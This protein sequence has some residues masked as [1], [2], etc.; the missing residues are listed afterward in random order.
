MPDHAD[1][2]LRSS[3]EAVESV[4]V[5]PP[6]RPTRGVMAIGLFVV[7][8]GFA[9]YL[10]F[11]RDG[12]APVTD[13]PAAPAAAPAA[14]PS[15][16]LGGT[17]EAIAV[18]PLDQSDPLVRDLVGRLS[19]NPRVAAWLTTDGLIRNFTVVVANIA[20]GRTPASHLRTVAPTGP[21]RIVERGGD[22]FIDPRSYERYDRLADA[23]ASVDAPGSARLYAT[24]KP[25]I[26]EASQELGQSGASFDRMMERAIVSL[27]AVPVVEGSVEVGPRGIVYG[28]ADPALESM[29][30]AQK[31]LLRMGPRNVR[32]IQD[33][34]RE[35][36]QALGI[37]SDRLRP[38]R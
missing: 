33:K 31:H 17:P 26:E 30:P 28:Y 20:E 34:L 25:R 35:I 9:I 32:I 6:N 19:S 36:A 23:V 13:Q 3:P 4:E 2:D 37:P 5:R 8:A 16:P 27:L 22:Q 12:A 38:S 10:V 7:A 14:A 18:P 21:F 15:Q 24:L 1:L 29:T 11:G